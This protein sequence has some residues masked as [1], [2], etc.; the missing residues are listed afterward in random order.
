MTISSAAASMQPSGE[1]TELPCTSTESARPRLREFLLRLLD[2]QQGRAVT[3]AEL[4]HRARDAGYGARDV[5]SAYRYLVVLE[6]HG[7]VQRVDARGRHVYWAR[8]TDG[9]HRRLA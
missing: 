4:R 2:E 5:E 6:H 8:I 1:H 3:T 7:Q 9:S